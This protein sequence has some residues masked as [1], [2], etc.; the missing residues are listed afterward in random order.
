M[1]KLL[2]ITLPPGEGK[3]I[4]VLGD[5]YTFKATG[6]DTGGSFTFVDQVIQPGS[7][8]PPHVHHREDETFYILEGKFS[9]LN[10]DTQIEASAGHF[11]YIPKGTWHTF[12]NISDKQGK[13]LTLISPGGLE[14]FF[15]EIGEPADTRQTPPPVD[16]GIVEKI[17]ALAPRYHME[18]KLPA[19]SA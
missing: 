13:L 7:G 12:K 8:P 15:E 5:L 18:I 17:M 4:W 3:S 11:V 2:P 1:E 14:A 19:P 6:K 9:F 10:G 16:P